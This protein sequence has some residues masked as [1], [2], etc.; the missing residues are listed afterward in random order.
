MYNHGMIGFFIIARCN[1]RYRRVFHTATG[2]QRALYSFH[3]LVRI[4]ADHHTVILYRSFYRL[5]RLLPAFYISGFEGCV[6]SRGLFCTRHHNR[7]FSDDPAL[8]G[9]PGKVMHAVFRIADGLHRSGRRHF[10]IDRGIS[11]LRQLFM[12]QS[13]QPLFFSR[14][15]QVTGSHYHIIL[16]QGN[17][18]IITAVFTIELTL[19]QVRNGMPAFVVIYCRFGKPLCDLVA[20]PLMSQSGKCFRNFDPERSLNTSLPSRYDRLR[21]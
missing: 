6:Y 4:R 7:I 3:R 9:K 17:A 10:F 2:P 1:N 12:R 20:L 11:R 18:H 13:V 14:C 5:C 16:R 21:Q 15:L 19:I 8:I